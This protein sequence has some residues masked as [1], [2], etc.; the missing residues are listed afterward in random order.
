ER[1]VV[2][3]DFAD[4]IVYPRLGTLMPQWR[5]LGMPTET[6]SR[7]ARPKQGVVEGPF[8]GQRDWRPGDSRRWIHWRSS[9]RRNELVVRQFE[10]QQN[11]DLTLVV[12][13]WRP[14]G[15]SAE[16]LER[17]ETA[18]SF[19]ATVVE[20]VCREG[21]VQIVVSIGG[22]KP[23]MISGPASQPLL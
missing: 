3:E 18:I 6:G 14:T 1:R 9:A 17:V 8:Y 5:Q 12:E 19:A 21:G 15:A 4:L 2:V 11:Q 23:N 10:Q 22:A 7:K 13:L 20:D 16:E